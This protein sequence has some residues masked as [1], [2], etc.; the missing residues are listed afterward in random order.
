MNNQDIVNKITNI[1]EPFYEFDINSI[2]G[3]RG[4]ASL[5]SVNELK[6]LY[7]KRQIIYLLPTDEQ[8]LVNLVKQEIYPLETSIV[9]FPGIGKFL[10]VTL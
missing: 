5:P 6:I 7:F 9:K 10:Q 8:K 2:Y 1:I 3:D 4:S